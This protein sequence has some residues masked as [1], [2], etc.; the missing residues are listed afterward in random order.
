MPTGASFRDPSRQNPGDLC[1]RYS[2]R[3]PQGGGSSVRRTLSLDVL[4][5]RDPFRSTVQVLALRSLLQLLNSVT[6]PPRPVTHPAVR[7]FETLIRL[8]S[9]IGS[10][11]RMT[12]ELEFVLAKQVPAFLAG[13]GTPNLPLVSRSR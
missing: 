13:P 10:G 6:P 7:T 11:R 5:E 12:D 9:G 2:L 8:V 4:F 1:R 3:C